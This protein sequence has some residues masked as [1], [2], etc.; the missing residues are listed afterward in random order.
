M[1]EPSRI[2]LEPTAA[3]PRAPRHL[4]APSRALWRRLVGDYAFETHHFPVLRLALEALDRAEQARSAI[5]R[6]GLTV[7]GRYGP[8][9]HPAIPVERD[10]AIRASRLFRE[11]GL[12]LED[13]RPPSRWK[14]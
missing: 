5:A 11:L 14:G 9:P 6:D 7:A 2:A 3:I 12:D 8:R 1:I 4:S 10:S 13:P